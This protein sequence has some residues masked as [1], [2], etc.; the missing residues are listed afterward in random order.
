MYAPGTILEFSIRNV[1]F[2]FRYIPSGSFIM[3]SPKTEK[4]RCDDEKQHEV[5]IT[6][7]FWMA[8]TPTTQK[9]YEIIT[10]ENPSSFEGKNNPVEQVS[11]HDSVKFCELLTEKLKH[12]LKGR[13]FTLPTEEQWEY[14]CR[15]GTTGPYNVDGEDL[16]ELGWFGKNSNN[17]THPVGQKLPNNWGLYDMHGNV[18]EWCFTKYNE[19]YQI[20]RGG[21]WDFDSVIARCSFR[22]RIHPYFRYYVCGFR[23]MASPA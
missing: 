3:G 14:A 22:Y 21:C 8:E 9:Q 19:K 11:W 7:S 13:T 16:E 4:G 12:K 6:K 1:I 10:G 18:W 20:L 23:V 15:A 2:R 17:T 5:I